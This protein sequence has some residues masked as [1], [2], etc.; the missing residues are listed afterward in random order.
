MLIHTEFTIEEIHALLVKGIK[1]YFQKCNMTKAVL[2]LSGGI[3]SAVV[4]ALAVEA[5]GKE[6]VHGLMLP[7]EFSTLHSIQDAVDLADNLGIGYHV[8]AISEIYNKMMKGLEE[9]FKDKKEWSVTEENLQARIRGTLLMAYSNKFNALLLNTSNKSELCTGYGTLYGDLAGAIMVIADLYKGDVYELAYDINKDSEIIPINT[10]T[11]APS[12][13]LHPGQLDSDSLPDYED[14]DPI[15]YSLNEGGKTPE[16]LEKEGV[17]KE[18][19][20]RITSL[21]G[22]SSFKI[23]QIPPILNISSAPLVY[24]QK[25]LIKK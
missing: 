8:V 11:K 25:C 23:H 1:D 17:D 10:L 5:L 22:K 3:D 7:S 13:E 12:A 2:G 24:P 18:L 14:M 16:E 4:A 21:M 19:L 9:V 15:L 20:S 6:N